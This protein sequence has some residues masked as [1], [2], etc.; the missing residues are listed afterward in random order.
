M[1]KKKKREC[2]GAPRSKPFYYHFHGHVARG[3]KG[4]REGAPFGIASGGKG[5]RKFPV[6]CLSRASVLTSLPS[7][8]KEG[9]RKKKV[10]ATVCQ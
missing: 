10:A 4:R 2:E 7:G 9:G 8:E 3:E 1:R 5:K 6:P